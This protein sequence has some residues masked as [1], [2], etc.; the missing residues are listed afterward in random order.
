MTSE[1]RFSTK[2][3]IDKPAADIFD[4]FVDPVLLTRFWLGAASGPTRKGDTVAWDFMVGGSSE[5][6]TVTEVIPDRTIAFRWSSGIDVRIAL[7]PHVTTGQVV[8]VSLGGFPPH[9]ATEVIVNAV[10]GFTTVLDDL[11]VLLETG[12]S[13]GLVRDQARLIEVDQTG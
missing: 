13:P 5:Q 8:E 11:K 7:V 3:L 4:H 6:T 9:D 12:V 2:V 10:R 1:T